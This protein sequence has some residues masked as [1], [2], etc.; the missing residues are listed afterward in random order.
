VADM[1]NYL[2]GY[3][4]PSGYRKVLVAPDYLRPAILD[5]IERTIEAHSPERPARIRMKMNSLVDP[6]CIQALYRASQAGVEIDLN[7]RGA[8]PTTPMAG[9]SRPA[10]G[11][12]AATRVKTRTTPRS[13]SWSSMPATRPRVLV[14]PIRSPPS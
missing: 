14:R 9:S 1:F 6:V 10:G 2:T 11:G 5:E 12:G 8:W 13:S 3:G 4:R 7:V